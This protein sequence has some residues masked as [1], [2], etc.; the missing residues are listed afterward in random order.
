MR[1][2][3]VKLRPVTLKL[4]PLTY[5]KE[6][7][8]IIKYSPS[9]QIAPILE[10][11]KSVKNVFIVLKTHW[12]VSQKSRKSAQYYRRNLREKLLFWNFVCK[13]SIDYQTKKSK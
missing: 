11:L 9:L 6:F 7:K 10:R 1:L 8:P 3:T 5:E 2:F 13:N 4:K 12:I